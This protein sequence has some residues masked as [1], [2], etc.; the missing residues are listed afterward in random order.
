MSAYELSVLLHYY[1]ER[2]DHPDLS[3]DNGSIARWTSARVALTSIGLLT[4]PTQAGEHRAWCLSEKGRIFVD[5]VLQTPLPVVTWK[6]P[7]PR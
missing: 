5:A 6:M 4:V 2:G 3:G 7:E 1:S